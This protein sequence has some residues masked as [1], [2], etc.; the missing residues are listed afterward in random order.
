[1]MYWQPFSKTMISI[2]H[3]EILQTTAVHQNKQTKKLYHLDVK[4]PVSRS[5][6]SRMNDERNAVLLKMYYT[7]VLARVNLA[8]V[9]DTITLI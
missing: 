3:Y 9:N 5:A 4:Y 6:L 1:M 2:N 7:I 8:R